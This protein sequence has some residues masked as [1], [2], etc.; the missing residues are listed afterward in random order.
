MK[1]MEGY[2]NAIKQGLFNGQVRVSKHAQERLK[3]RGYSKKDIVIAIMK[4]TITEEQER[5]GHVRYVIE[6]IDSY[7]DPI[8][9]VFTKGEDELFHIVT[10]MPPHDANRFHQLI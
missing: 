5:K 10:V 2:L 4:G 8:V 6:S 7:N 3:K 9:V 1:V